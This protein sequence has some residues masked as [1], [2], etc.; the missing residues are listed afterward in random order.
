MSQQFIVRDHVQPRRRCKP[1]GWLAAIFFPGMFLLAAVTQKGYVSILGS[2]L[3]MAVAA[4]FLIRFVQEQRILSVP[5]RGVAVITF[6][7]IKGLEAGQVCS[8]RYRFTA[9][10]GKEYIGRTGWTRHSSP[11]GSEIEVVYRR[12]QPSRNFAIDDFRFYEA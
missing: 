6:C 5:V 11:V 8:M 2:I 7:D 12:D 10:D 4:S 1:S 3:G 9:L